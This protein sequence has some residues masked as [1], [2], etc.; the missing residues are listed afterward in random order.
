MVWEGCSQWEEGRVVPGRSIKVILHA[1]IG[2]WTRLGHS[3]G[4]QGEIWYLESLYVRGR[5]RRL[6][7]LYLEKGE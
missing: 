5:S 1:D 4:S 7:W 2:G 3:F 6:T